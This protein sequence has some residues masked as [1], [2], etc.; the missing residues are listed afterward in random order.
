MFLFTYYQPILE[1]FNHKR[2]KESNSLFINITDIMIGTGCALI[3][4]PAFLKKFM[5]QCP[6]D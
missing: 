2:V 1:Y 3:V 6:H 5:Q 4:R